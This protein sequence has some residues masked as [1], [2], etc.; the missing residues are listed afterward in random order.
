M[1]VDEMIS[2]WISLK[3]F[4]QNCEKLYLYGAGTWAQ[5]IYEKMEKINKRIDGVVVSSI[6]S[7]TTFNNLNVEE[8]E[9]I[10]TYLKSENIGII[11]AMS[12]KFSREVEKILQRDEQKYYVINTED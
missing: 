1:D 7:F 5:I 6:G 9:T 11:V 10:K 8:Y 4:C 2:D 12:H 3:C